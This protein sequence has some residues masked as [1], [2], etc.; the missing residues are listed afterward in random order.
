MSVTRP[1]NYDKLSIH[2]RLTIKQH[3]M[4]TFG[5]R[6]HMRNAGHLRKL[7]QLQILSII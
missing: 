2:Q 1:T 6:W 5:K 3:G 4:D 7:N